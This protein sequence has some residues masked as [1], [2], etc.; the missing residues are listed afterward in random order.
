MKTG[1]WQAFEEVLFEDA[2]RKFGPTEYEKI[3]TIV[4]TRTP[5]QVYDHASAPAVRSRLKEVSI[6][7]AVLNMT[8]AQAAAMSA[9]TVLA[10]W[11]NHTCGG[12]ASTC[13]EETAP[14]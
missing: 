14:E 9:Q 11:V 12:A 13:N 6:E 10:R 7:Q 8:S 3:A 1:R 4:R 2:V 5:K